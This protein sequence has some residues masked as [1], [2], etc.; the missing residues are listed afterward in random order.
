MLGYGYCALYKGETITEEVIK[1]IEKKK[2]E[3]KEEL[4]ERKKVIDFNTR[5]PIY[6]FYK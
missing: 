3:F 6:K 1:E 5:K 2:E 4:K